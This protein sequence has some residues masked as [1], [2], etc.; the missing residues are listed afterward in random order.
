MADFDDYEMKE[1]EQEQEREMERVREQQELEEA[2]Q[3]QET[4]FDDDDDVVV[5]I[6][7]KDDIPD[8]D[9]DDIPDVRKDVANIKRSITSDVKKTFKNVFNVSIEKKNGFNSKRVL[10]NTKFVS[11]KNGRISIGLKEI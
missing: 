10:E 8:L 4:N 11:S 2:D 6:G 5:D 3:E 1:R 9:L 7:G